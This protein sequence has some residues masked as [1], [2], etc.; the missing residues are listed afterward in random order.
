M[1]EYIGKKY[2][3]LKVI[4]YDHKGKYNEKYY[5]F[6]CECGNKKIINFQN[7]KSGKTKSCGCNYKEILGKLNKKENK[8]LFK[9]NYVIGYT[10]NTSKIF[11]IDKEDYDKIKDISWYEDYN[12]YICHKERNKKVILMHRLITKCPNNKIVDHINHNKKDNRK[13]NLRITDYSINGLNKEKLPKGICKI[14]SGKKK[15]YVIQL[16]GYR[17]ICK[18]YKEAREK[19]N[20]IIKEEYLVLRNYI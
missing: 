8:Y 9:K 5:L 19:R 6:E 18:T 20:K 1:D 7:V 12:G 4:S 14:K 3:K 2:N 17:G 13:N 11:Y 15:Y 16:K 10:T